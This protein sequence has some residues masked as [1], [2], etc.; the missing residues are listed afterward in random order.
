MDGYYTVQEVAA[1][2]NLTTRRIQKMCSDG[3]IPGVTKFGRSWVVPVNA[4]KPADGRVTTGKYRNW[5][6][7]TEK[8]TEKRT[9]IKTEI[10]AGEKTAI[11][12]TGERE[13]LG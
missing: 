1:R 2:W 8:K 5:R 12:D 6:K 4:E 13:R 10:K 7:K 9:E 11:T 3:L